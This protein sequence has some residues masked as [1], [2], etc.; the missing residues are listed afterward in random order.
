MYVIYSEGERYLNS[1]RDGFVIR[2][3]KEG[4]SGMQFTGRDGEEQ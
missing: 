3:V 4:E 2:W 1:E